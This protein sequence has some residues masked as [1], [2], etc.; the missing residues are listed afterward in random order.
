MKK[1]FTDDNAG[2]KMEATNKRVPSTL[3]D[4]NEGE[5]LKLREEIYALLPVKTLNELDLTQE[6]V[7]QYRAAL[8][9][10]NEVLEGNEESNKK[11]QVLN[12]CSSA[13]QSLVKM[14]GDFYTPERLKSIE[15]RLMK[16]LL[17]VPKE[18]LVEF[19]NWYESEMKP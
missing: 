3:K 13:L 19:F 1:L 17:K 8:N 10:Q 5:L 15:S 7:L 6:V 2:F 14:Q 16:A 9:L 18:Q 4:L 11:A 12:T